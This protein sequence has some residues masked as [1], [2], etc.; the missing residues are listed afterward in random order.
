MWC[1]CKWELQSK[2]RLIKI[3]GWWILVSG[4]VVV[5]YR[6]WVVVS[7]MVVHYCAWWIVVFGMGV[8]RVRIFLF[9]LCEIMVTSSRKESSLR[10]MV[11]AVKIGQSALVSSREEGGFRV[12][13]CNNSESGWRDFVV[14]N[15]LNIGDVL[16][17]NLVAMSRFVVHVN[18][19]FDELGVSFTT[20]LIDMKS[21]ACCSCF[22]AAF[23]RS[24]NSRWKRVDVLDYLLKPLE[25][26][27]C[28]CDHH[29]HHGQ[30]VPQRNGGARYNH[31][32]FR[33]VSKS[34]RCQPEFVKELCQT[35]VEGSRKCPSYGAK[36]VSKTL[37]W[38]RIKSSELV[39]QLELVTERIE[40]ELVFLMQFVFS[41]VAAAKG[42][43]SEFRASLPQTDTLHD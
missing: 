16:L 32:H 10:D 5:F 13:C 22:P 19:E 30:R 37:V 24:E 9:S 34:S 31:E 4:I 28:T 2:L 35:H 25:D 38:D 20:E 6:A 26:L 33:T 29:R 39:L 7:G 40:E 15:Q 17:F 8:R 11:V 12:Y 41:L 14:K 3:K 27:L 21:S 36:L 23:D 42:D 18:P 1:Y 43:T